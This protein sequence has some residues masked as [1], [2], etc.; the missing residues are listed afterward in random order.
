M[1]KSFCDFCGEEMNER[2]KSATL[3]IYD[4]NRNQPQHT[5][6]GYY[7]LSF[8]GDDRSGTTMEM[9]AGC[10]GH[11]LP[12]TQRIKA[13]R[14]AAKGKKEVRDGVITSELRLSVPAREGAA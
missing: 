10:L 13:E 1:T 5:I 4:R 11:L 8:G 2:D 14:E 3:T 7:V 12:V 9:C 6:S